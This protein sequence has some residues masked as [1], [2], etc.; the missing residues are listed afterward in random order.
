[1][2]CVDGVV[3]WGGRAMGFVVNPVKPMRSASTTFVANPVK[4]VRSARTTGSSRR[5]VRVVTM[6]TTPQPADADQPEPPPKLDFLAGIARPER[7]RSSDWARNLNNFSR[8]L[9]IR[10]IQ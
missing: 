8:S 5:R 7:Y 6:V 2:D 10:R 4:P 1:M 9:V 3:S